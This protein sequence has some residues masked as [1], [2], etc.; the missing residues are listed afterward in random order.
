[1][2]KH[3][4]DIAIV[5][6]VVLAMCGSVSASTSPPPGSAPDSCTTSLLL[7]GIAGGLG[8]VRKFVR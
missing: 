4:L 1:M 3:M 5:L 6:T 8:L 2:K 7:A